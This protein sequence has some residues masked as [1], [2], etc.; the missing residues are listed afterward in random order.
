[1]PVQIGESENR[2]DRESIPFNMS[3][4]SRERFW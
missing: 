4:V 1:M 3:A 2:A